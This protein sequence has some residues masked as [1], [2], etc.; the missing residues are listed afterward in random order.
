DGLLTSF[1]RS[2]AWSI[3]PGSPTV[4]VFPAGYTETG[5]WFL[6]G[7]F[8]QLVYSPL[9]QISVT[10]GAR[11]DTFQGEADPKFTPRVGVVYKPMDLLAV[12]AL[13]GQSYLAPMW[14]HKRASD[15]NFQGNPLLKPETFDGFDF[16]VSYGEKKA[17]A[18]LDLFY[19]HVEGVINSVRVEPTNP[20]N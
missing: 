4:R 2:D 5:K 18:T 20:Q 6:G 1:H 11:Y 16:I 7:A 3:A 13:Y 14:A 17:S 15:G 10:A 12:K 19:N 8:L 9:K